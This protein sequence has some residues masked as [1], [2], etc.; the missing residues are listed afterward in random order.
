MTMD[1]QAFLAACEAVV[2]RDR[3]K[4]GIGTLGEKTLHSVL[5]HYFMPHSDGQEIRLGRYVADVV[6][7]D[8]IVE[9]Q[10]QSFHL[11]KKKLAALLDCGRVTVVYPIPK[12]KWLCWIDEETGEVTKRRKSPKTGS[13]CE[14][15]YELYKLKPLLS[16]PNL[17][18]CLTLLEL[19]EYRHLNGWSHDK[20][21]GS[22]RCDRI[23][24]ALL[25]QIHIGSPREYEKLL[26]P[27]LPPA[28]TTKDF[29]KAAGI[30]PR[31]SQTAL[32]VLLHLGTVRRTGKSG[33]L[34]LYER[35]EPPVP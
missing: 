22:T 16:H 15:F 2:G 32:N 31:R 21:R 33:R 5:K 8:G 17:R 1:R 26:P 35:S 24:S 9:I 23:P 34:Y 10:T 30:P 29:A 18:L 3:E 14:A 7:E 13:P 4:N 6:G 19:T 11:L 25:E 12:T 20:K 28:F 27:G